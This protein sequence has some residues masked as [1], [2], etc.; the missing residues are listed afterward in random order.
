VEG[1]EDSGGT[2]ELLISLG[3]AEE[4]TN[5]KDKWEWRIDCRLPS[6]HEGKTGMVCLL[7]V[8]ERD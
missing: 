8:L 3:R 5:H 1:D 6:L 7:R 2:N 4:E